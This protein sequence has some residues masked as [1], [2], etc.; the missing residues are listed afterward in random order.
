M[1]GLWKLE[2]IDHVE[3]RDN[4]DHVVEP[5]IVDAIACCLA[6]NVSLFR[7]NRKIYSSFWF[8]LFDIT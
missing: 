3:Q 8:S 1:P 7:A 5:H 6:V 2:F 4:E